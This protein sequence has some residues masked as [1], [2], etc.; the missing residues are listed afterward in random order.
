MSKTNKRKLSKK[1]IEIFILAIVAILFIIKGIPVIA[2]FFRSTET[3]NYGELKISEPV[4]CLVVRDETVYSAGSDSKISGSLAEGTP[5]RVNKKIMNLSK[6]EKDTGAS[7]FE[8]YSERLGDALITSDGVSKKRGILSYY[9]DGYEQICSPQ[10][11]KDIKYKDFGNKDIKPEN[12]SGGS[13][14]KGD[15]IFKISDNGNWYLVFWIKQNDISKYE[16]GKSVTAEFKKGNV[17]GIVSSIN[18]D[19]DMW[20][21]AVKTNR[22]YDDFTK[23][24][25]IEGDIV[26]LSRKGLIIS[27][28]ALTTK[29]K[30]VG[31]YVKN[32]SGDFVFKQ[33][34]VLATDGEHTVVTNTEFN[35][36]DGNL[37]KTVKDYDEI[38]KKPK[39]N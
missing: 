32:V 24:R 27:N 14:K 36:K 25:Y 19:G 29:N 38:L 2:D 8:E 4:K 28:S 30:K 3:V 1:T 37:I 11:I 23:Y 17:R 12:I 35:D 33:V 13:A 5:T 18:A 10:K 34:N 7:S 9:I 15:P 21:V 16:V 6:A 22:K 39:K 31:C 20:Q 26:T